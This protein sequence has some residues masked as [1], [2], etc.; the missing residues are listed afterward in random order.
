MPE[1]VCLA[2][3]AR[4]ATDSPARGA[5][6]HIRVGQVVARTLAADTLV[7][8]MRL[9]GTLDTHW[10]AAVAA[11]HSLEGAHTQGTSSTRVAL[12]VARYWAQRVAALPQMAEAVARLGEALQTYRIISPLR[13]TSNE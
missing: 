7:D 8:R 9:A 12:Q 5:A 2:Q 4:L 1:K 11:C 3:V 10:A 13:C 6:P